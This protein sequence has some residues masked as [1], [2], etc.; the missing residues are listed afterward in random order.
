[1]LDI[2]AVDPLLYLLGAVLVQLGWI[3]LALT[4]DKRRDQFIDEIMARLGHQR[5]PKGK[6]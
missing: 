2:L 1:M 4:R 6:V 3:C 5:P